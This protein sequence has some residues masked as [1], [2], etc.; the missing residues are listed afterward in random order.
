M[1]NCKWRHSLKDVRVF[2][3]ADIGSDHNLASTSIRLS[4]SACRQQRKQARFDSAKLLNRDILKSFDA[5][6]GGSFHVLADLDETADI[7]G[8]WEHFSKTV[9]DAATAHLGYRKGKKDEWISSQ[10]S[11]LIAKRKVARPSYDANYKDLNRGKLKR[12]SEMT[13]RTGME[14]WQITWKQRRRKTT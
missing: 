10:S 9:N 13:G 7:D 4:L 12:A 6:I 11:D 3:G 8:E 2:R 5:T 1:I 14:R